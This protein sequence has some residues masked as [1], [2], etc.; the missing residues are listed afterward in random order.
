MEGFGNWFR[1]HTAAVRIV[2]ILAVPPG[3]SLLSSTA[4]PRG[5]RWREGLSRLD[6]QPWLIGEKTMQKWSRASGAGVAGLK[7]KYEDKEA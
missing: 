3:K 5:R 2:S 7:E 6:M 4:R 1:R